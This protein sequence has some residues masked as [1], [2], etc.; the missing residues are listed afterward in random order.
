MPLVIKN[1][2]SG[3]QQTVNDADWSYMQS[4][5]MAK[6]FTIV[7]STQVTNRVVEI[8]DDVL[9]FKAKKSNNKTPDAPQV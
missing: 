3:H 8:P 9:S 7:S 2:K 4:K 6:R 1:K 5:G